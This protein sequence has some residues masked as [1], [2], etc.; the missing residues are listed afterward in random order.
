MIKHND[1]LEMRKEMDEDDVLYHIQFL[2]NKRLKSL[3]LF[4]H[5]MPT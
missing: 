3:V 4:I 5:Q 2:P 1:V